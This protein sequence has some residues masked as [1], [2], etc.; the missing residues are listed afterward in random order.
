[1]LQP[2]VKL[3]AAQ[4]GM[5]HEVL[6]FLEGAVLP[7]DHQGALQAGFHL[8][9][10][11][12]LAVLQ[13]KQETQQIRADGIGFHRMQHPLTAGGEGRGLIDQPGGIQPVLNPVQHHLNIRL[14]EAALQQVFDH[15]LDIRLGP[16][17]PRRSIA[18]PGR[19]DQRFS[20]SRGFRSG[21]GIDEPPTGA[22]AAAPKIAKAPTL[23]RQG[24]NSFEGPLN[25]PFSGFSWLWPGGS[26]VVG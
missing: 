21:Y 10:V 4:Q 6:Q 3:V 18:G 19:G 2:D 20:C 26:G 22:P 9:R 5:V 13:F 24:K 14:L 17:A 1:M 23:S 8:A 7:A 12:Q 15:G 16:A 11:D 25:R